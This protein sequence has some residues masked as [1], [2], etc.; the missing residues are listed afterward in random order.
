MPRE[1][2]AIFFLVAACGGGGGDQIDADPN[3]P[4]ADPNAPDADP[5]APDARV[6]TPDA[7]GGIGEPPEL[8]GITLFHNQ[9]RAGVG[10][11]IPPL[12][13]NEDLEATATAWAAMCVDNTAPAGLIDHN[14]NRSDGHPYYVGENIYGSSGQPNAQAVVTAWVSEESNYDYP[15]NS[16]SGVCGHY[17]QVVWRETQEIGCAMHLCPGL[18]YGYGVVCNYGPGG[19]DGSQPY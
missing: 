7:P 2:L 18:T 3:A 4:D 19:N 11:G 10:A 14:P 8:A 15:S 5:N 12:V 13:W 9:A 17:T 1:L 6:A 16:C